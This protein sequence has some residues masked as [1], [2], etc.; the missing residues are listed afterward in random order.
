[1]SLQDAEARLA[2][3]EGPRQQY[4]RAK[5]LHASFTD[6]LPRAKEK[7]AGHPELISAVEVAHGLAGAVHRDAKAAYEAHANGF[8]EQGFDLD[9]L[10]D[11]AAQAVLD[12]RGE[13]QNEEKV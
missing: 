1:M 11:E 13:A 12:A 6:E 7:F 3:L 4:H 10:I 5:H 2:E 8:K 9:L